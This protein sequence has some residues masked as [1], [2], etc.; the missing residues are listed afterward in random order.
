MKVGEDFEWEWQIC[1]IQL[2]SAS[3]G[4]FDQRI[5]FNPHIMKVASYGN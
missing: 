4:Y 5:L 1:V 3:I 2:F